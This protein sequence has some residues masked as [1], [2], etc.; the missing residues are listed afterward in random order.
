LLKYDVNM[1]N[2]THAPEGLAQEW[3]TYTTHDGLPTDYVRWVAVDGNYIW[4]AHYRG[5]NRYDKDSLT[6]TIYSADILGF[7]NIQRIKVGKRHVWFLTHH[8]GRMTGYDR[9]KDEW[10]TVKLEG[11]YSH[12]NLQAIVE[13]RDYIWIGTD[14]FGVLRYHKA[15]GISTAFDNRA[16]VMEDALQSDQD[17]ILAGT[18][19]GLRWYDKKNQTWLTYGVAHHEGTK[20]LQSDEVRA[21]AVD[22]DNVWCGTNRGV[23]QYNKMHGTWRNLPGHKRIA[24][25][26]VDDKYL[27][28]GT[29]SGAQKYD[30]IAYRRHNYTTAN[31]LPSEDITAIIVDGYNVW[32]GTSGGLCQY[33]TKSD[34]PNA[35][36]VYTSGVEIKPVILSEQYASSL[37]SNQVWSVAADSDYV[38]VGTGYGV[39]AYD[40]GQGTWTTYTDEDGLPSNEISSIA[41]AGDDVWFGTGRGATK[42][43]KKSREWVTF[44]T[45]DGLGSDGVTQ[46]VVDGEDIWFGTFDGGVTRYSQQ[47]ETWTT[48][49]RKDGLVHNTILSMAVDGNYLWVG[50]PRGLNRYDKT[51]DTWTTYRRDDD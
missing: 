32:M 31:G 27:W 24:S 2:P 25:L 15:S 51:A 45:E 36:V 26:A 39:S 3:K 17:V 19:S 11:E 7:E 23:S 37:V 49:T 18:S 38:W 44:T 12:A 20:S 21:L 10:V 30:K 50:T 48:F 8:R 47:T 28:I 1:Q 29:K 43:Y 4:V 6:W 16:Y 22:D 41:V 13:D 14:D 33:P 9:E 40:K 34:D 46:I 35:W 42:H 5:V